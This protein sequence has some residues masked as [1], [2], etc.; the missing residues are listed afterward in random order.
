MLAQP[1]SAAGMGEMII[2]PFCNKLN[3]KNQRYIS[4]KIKRSQ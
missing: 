3:K 2:Q 4:K 1:L